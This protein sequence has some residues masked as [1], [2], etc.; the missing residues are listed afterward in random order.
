MA[1]NGLIEK[2]EHWSSRS[3][4]IFASIGSAIG[5]GNIWRF[6][7]ICAENGGAAF[8]IAYVVALFTT[9]I[10]IL[11][12]ELAV[13]QKVQQATPGC[14]K[15]V[16]KNFEW[17]GWCIVGVGF[18]ITTYYAVIMGWGCNYFIFSFTRE[19]GAAPREF[20]YSTFLKTSPASALPG[21][22]GKLSIPILIGTIVSWVFIIGCIWKGVK[23]VSKVVYFTVLA[24]WA[25]L[26]IFVIRGITLPG[27]MDGLKYYLF[28]KAQSGYLLKASTWLNAYTQ[29][30]FSLS[31]GFG[32][33]FAYGSFMNPKTSIVKNAFIIGISD[34]LTAFVGGLAVFCALGYLAT[35]EGGGIAIESWMGSSLGICFVAYPTL[36]NKLPLAGLFG[37]LFFLMLLTLAVDSA[38]S[39]VEAAI[40][41]VEDKFKWRH[42]KA[43][44]IVCALAFVLGFP[45]MF[46][47]GL[48]WFDTLDNFMNQFGLAGA[49]L[50]ECIILGY[51]YRASKIR[52]DLKQNPENRLGIWWE[53]MILY[54]SPLVLIFLIGHEVLERIKKSYEGYPRSV[55]F[56]GGWFVMILIAVVALI[57]TLL[58]TKTQAEKQ[59]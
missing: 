26:I 40:A 7:R 35:P 15:K 22:W 38:F 45:H 28:L 34:S 1:N 5:L 52:K 48:Y 13:G 12:L 49:C 3:A 6:P 25:L 24:P 56:F 47:S 8:L 55:E 53:W 27:A 31:I 11:I 41:P 46:Q 19:W 57:M 14:F 16:K 10:P 59:E 4:F 32:I 50:I 44:F 29:V 51:V 39:L 30:F 42:K 54:I 36:I 23:T 58:K 9:G 43:M 18:M 33:M 37:P 17:I 2:R 20:F 21:G